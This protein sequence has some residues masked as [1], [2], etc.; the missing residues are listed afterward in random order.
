[1]LHAEEMFGN[2]GRDERSV[3]WILDLIC[4]VDLQSY[5]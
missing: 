5:I 1:M 3:D 4:P 2:T